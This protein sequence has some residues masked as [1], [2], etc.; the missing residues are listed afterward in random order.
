MT[1]RCTQVGC[2][3]LVQDGQMHS[4][5][6]VRRILLPNPNLPQTTE[7]TPT[8]K[9]QAT[10]EATGDSATGYTRAVPTVAGAT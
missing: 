9:A 8:N 6:D 4:C 5:L 1:Y 7:V 3:A 2:N 10:A